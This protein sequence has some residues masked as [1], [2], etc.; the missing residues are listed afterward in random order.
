MEAE[1]FFNYRARARAAPQAYAYVG[2]CDQ[3]FYLYIHISLFPALYFTTF[4]GI[5]NWK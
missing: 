1:G 5:T 2:F 3:S 4:Y